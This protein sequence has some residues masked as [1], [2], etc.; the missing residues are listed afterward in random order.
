MVKEIRVYFEGDNALRKGFNNF[1][2]SEIDLAR[3]RDLRF[4]L[5][6]GGSTAETIKDFMT[7]ARAH[8]DAINIV[9]IDSDEPD[10]GNL[11]AE[12]K[13]RVSWDTEAGAKIQDEQIHFMVQ[14]MESWFLADRNALKKYYGQG[15][16]EGRLPGNQ[17]N[18]EQISKSDVDN[19][20]K[21]ATRDTRKKKYHKTRHAPDLLSNLD[22]DK[23]RSNAPSCNRLFASLRSLIIS[24]A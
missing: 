9:L 12:V 8:K 19:G 3:Q 15:F 7:A 14:V 5:I 4:N 17:N 24:N 6:A 11:I 10:N 18:V 13:R 16:R 1:L 2:K 21:N 22:V 23:V 20:L